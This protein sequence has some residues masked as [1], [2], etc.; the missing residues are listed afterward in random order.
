MQIQTTSGYIVNK[1]FNP[2]FKSAYPVYHWVREKGGGS[3]AP[4]ISHS[5]NKKLQGILVRLFNQTSKLS[6]TEFGQQIIKKLGPRMSDGV[7]DFDYVSN[8]VVRTF[9]D[10][11]GGWSGRFI[12]INY[13]ISGKDVKVFDENFGKPIGKSFAEAPKVEG[14][15]LSAEY[16]CAINDY[17]LG[18]LNFVKNKKKKI[19]DKNGLEYGLHTKFEV[20]RNKNGKIKGYD[21]VDIRFCP[22]TGEESPFVKLGYHKN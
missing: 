14:E 8:S 15:A 16:R 13:L 10:T 11:K 5:L 21:L 22:E 6:K 19:I 4:A 7:G 20:V 18:G 1:S 3:Y 9:N 2:Q 12:P 17:I